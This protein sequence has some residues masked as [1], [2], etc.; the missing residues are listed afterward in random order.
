L[1]YAVLI[2]GGFFQSLQFMAYNTIAYADIPRPQM[3]IATSFYTTFQQVFLTLGIAVSASAL[4]GSM[5]LN[6]HAGPMLGDFSVAFLLIAAISV[7]SPLFALQLDRSAG[8]ELSGQAA[9]PGSP[10]R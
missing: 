5:A 7:L 1:I 9:A 3:S 8:A 6:H 2:A 4:A 10:R